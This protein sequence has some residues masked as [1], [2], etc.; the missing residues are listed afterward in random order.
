MRILYLSRTSGPHDRRFLSAI[1]GLGHKVSFVKLGGPPG[2]TPDDLP[3]GVETV[4]WEGTRRPARLRNGLR[5]RVGLQSVI[6]DM[7]PDVVHAG[8]VQSGAF[9]AASVGVRP[10]V[11]MSWGSDILVGAVSGIGR[12]VAAWTLSRSALL[13]CDCEAVKRAAHDLGLPEHRIVVFPWG[14]DLS[15]FSPGSDGGLRAELGWQNAIVLL[16]AR[17]MEAQ[18]GVDTLVEGFIR[19]ARSDPRLRLLV[20]GNGTLRPLLSEQLREARLLDRVHW[21]G[22]VGLNRLH[23][24]YRSA[25]WY[26][27][28]SRS[29]G[30]SVALLEAMACGLPAMVSDIPGNREWVE[31][32][33]NGMLFA[34]G[35]A[36]ALTSCLTKAGTIGEE[37]ASWGRRSR[38]IAEAR[39][40]WR[41][42][43][44]KLQRAYELVACGGKSKP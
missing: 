29:D 12:W 15:Q 14:V 35:D 24:Y 9:L 11:T 34:V 37:W 26:V 25:D 44:A 31:P 41:N 21:A 28:A 32:G 30:S 6:A 2:S 22:T 39:A 8:P 40:D 3:E 1:V 16:S 38:A 19:A 33:E 42:G 4:A 27:S 20:L 43:V 7:R 18:Y 13:L 17:S 5:L 36:S 23:Q 10:L